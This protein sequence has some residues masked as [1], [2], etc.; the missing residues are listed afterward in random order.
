MLAYI[1]IFSCALA[2]FAGVPPFAIAVSAIALASISYG[3][4]FD[5]YRRG[6]ELGLIRDLNIVLLRSLTNGL[7]AATAAYLGGWAFKW[8]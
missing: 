4:N 1:A 7:L 6:R 3:E 2:G 8:L 5:L